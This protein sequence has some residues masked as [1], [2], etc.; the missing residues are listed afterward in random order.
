VLPFDKMG[1]VK[2]EAEQEH[3]LIFLLQRLGL[4]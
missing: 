2:R 4:L 1:G 3:S